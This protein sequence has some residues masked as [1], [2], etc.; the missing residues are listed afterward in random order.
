MDM[1]VCLKVKDIINSE[2][3]VST[4]N[5]GDVFDLISINFKDN[6]KVILSFDGI[7]LLTPVF[8][9]IA[10][11]CLYRDFKQEFVESHLSYINLP[12]HDNER[13]IHHMCKRAIRY[14]ANYDYFTGLTEKSLTCACGEN[15]YEVI[16]ITDNSGEEEDH[17][18][19]TQLKCLSCGETKIINRQTFE[20]WS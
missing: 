4:E 1:E 11:G 18:S 19:G 8:F 7:K 3:A 15:K 16:Y 12:E 20:W 14:F 9:N 6:N 2:W 10:V 17:W 13:T 5:A